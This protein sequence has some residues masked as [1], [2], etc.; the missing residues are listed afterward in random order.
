MIDLHRVVYIS[1]LAIL[2]SVLAM[3][4]NGARRPMEKRIYV[5][6][7]ETHRLW[8]GYATESRFRVQ[9]QTLKAPIVGTID[10]S[11]GRVVAISLT[12]TDE[13][14]DWAVNDEYTL[15]AA[16]DVLTLRRK[17]NIIPEDISEEQAFRVSNGKA[18]LRSSAYRLL[19]SGMP[20]D[21][22]VDWFEPPSVIMKLR[23]FPFTSLLT[24]SRQDMLRVGGT[25]VAG[26]LK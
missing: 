13:T 9:V 12:Q 19:S 8:C 16:G 10:Y 15:D 24:V 3:A 26:N 22:R 7:D 18:T 17:T 2:H 4:Q 23:D 25:C 21:K 1:M 5:L 11:G 14:G 6:Q 20:T